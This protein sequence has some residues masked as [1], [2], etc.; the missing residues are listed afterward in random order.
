MLQN[1]L[2]ER[3]QAKPPC[4]VVEPMPDIPE[5]EL[6]TLSEEDL[7][8]EK[9][10]RSEQLRHIDQTRVDIQYAMRKVIVEE[11]LD[12]ASEEEDTHTTELTKTERVILQDVGQKMPFNSSWLKLLEIANDRQA[13]L[14]AEEEFLHLMKPHVAIS[15]RSIR[16]AY[17]VLTTV[18]KRMGRMNENGTHRWEYFHCWA[19]KTFGRIR[20]ESYEEALA[21]DKKGYD[22]RLGRIIYVLAAQNTKPSDFSPPS[23][24]S[25]FNVS[26]REET[27]VVL[28]H[29]ADI[30]SSARLIYSFSLFSDSVELFK[31]LKGHRM[32]NS[33]YL[34]AKGVNPG[35]E[36]AVKEV[37]RWKAQWKIAT[38][39]TE[40]IE[41]EEWGALGRTEEMEVE[42][43]I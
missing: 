18:L 28:L 40:A 25:R 22:G 17:Q 7:P 13:W 14:K 30:W 11:D 15:E 42:V 35:R 27:W 23:W 26:V 34:V 4:P 43:V 1:L 5:T 9:E 38:F 32:K 8:K 21:S 19:R 16:K 6:N 2:A 24:F 39:G 36:A 3:A 20:L 10:A 33:F 12:W 31:P 37:K 29:K 41:E